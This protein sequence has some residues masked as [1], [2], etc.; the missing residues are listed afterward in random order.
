MKLYQWAQRWNVPIQAIRELEALMGVEP[1]PVSG[2]VEG[3]SET[4]VQNR[5]RLKAAKAGEYLWRNNSGVLEDQTGRPVRYGLANDSA[6]YN[7]VVK[8]SD[9]IGIRAVE[10]QPEHVGTRI[11]QFVAR[12]CK[13]QGWVF[14]GTEREIAQRRFIELVVSLGGDAAFVS[15]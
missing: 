12:E 6:R 15:R 14:T 11:G 13:P 1:P 10:I 7:K 3:L 9:L 4:A 2:P 5:A 8:S